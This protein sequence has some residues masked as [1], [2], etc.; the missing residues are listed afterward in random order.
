MFH[1]VFM[2]LNVASEV[3]KDKGIDPVG[4]V[5]SDT[6]GGVVGD[7]GKTQCFL[8][9]RTGG[10]S[11]RKTTENKKVNNYV[12]HEVV[13]QDTKLQIVVESASRGCPFVE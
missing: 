6:E 7:T 4:D 13:D 11:C 10:K 2:D 9:I 5:F 3:G 1:L 12:F 8:F